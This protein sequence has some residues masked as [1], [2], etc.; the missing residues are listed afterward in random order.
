MSDI[1]EPAE[2][3]LKDKHLLIAADKKINREITVL[4][5]DTGLLIDTAINGRE[6]V[7]MTAEAPFKY[8]L[9]LLD[10]YMP[11][12]DGFEAARRIRTLEKSLTG[13]TVLRKGRTRGIPIIAVTDSLYHGEMSKCF[14]FG[15]D[16]CLK[17]PLDMAKLNKKICDYLTWPPIVR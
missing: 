3:S 2:N 11:V 9:I 17:K 5:K 6:V 4:L 15:I 12:I 10:L 16:D 13:S 7:E 14:S 1:K 8:D